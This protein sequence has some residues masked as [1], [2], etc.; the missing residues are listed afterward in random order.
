VVAG[1]IGQDHHEFDLPAIE[2]IE[3]ALQGYAATLVL[4]T[5]DR[6]LIAAVGTDRVVDVVDGRLGSAADLLLSQAHS[7]L[8]LGG[9]RTRRESP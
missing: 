3:R 5:H 6:R 8:R 7:L 2:Q 9:V 4:V 1:E